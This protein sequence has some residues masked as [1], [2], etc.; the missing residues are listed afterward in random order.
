MN[1]T[2]QTTHAACNAAVVR[3]LNVLQRHR[4][5]ADAAG[6]LA[7]EGRAHLLHTVGG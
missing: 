4:A 2:P 5:T 1:P 6:D 7:N 3:A